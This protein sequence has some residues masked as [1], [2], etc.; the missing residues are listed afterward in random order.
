MK[1]TVITVCYQAEAV[2]RPTI[3][4]VLSQDGI[5]M[6]YRIIDGASKDRTVAIAEEYRPAFEKKGF[7][8]LSPR[9]RT[10]AFMTP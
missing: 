10:R 9:S 2:I 3:E 4:S 5:D 7:P 6:E 8:F 1:L